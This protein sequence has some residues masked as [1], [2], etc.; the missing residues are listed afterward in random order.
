MIP[1]AVAAVADI[2][3]GDLVS[4]S[5]T[6]IT[7]VSIDSRRV[8][9]G[10]LFVP[11]VGEHSDGHDWVEAAVEAGAAGFLCDEAHA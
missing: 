5:D 4:D 3:G 6:R 1:L 8:M 7:G 2:V 10:D 9:A 11:L